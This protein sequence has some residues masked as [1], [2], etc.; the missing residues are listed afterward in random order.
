MSFTALIALVRKDL[1][2]F[3]HDRRSV[4]MSFAAPIVIASFFG[5]LFQGTS[6]QGNQARIPVAVVDQ[7]QTELSEKLIARLRE[8]KQVQVE[9]LPLDQALDQVRRGKTT[10]A[11]RIPAGFSE[12]ATRTFFSG[13]N[14]PELVLD[15]DPSHTMELGLVRGLLTEAAM[16]VVSAEMFTGPAGRKSLDTSLDQLEHSHLAGAERSDLKRLLESA[17]AWNIRQEQQPATERQS[18]LSLP[19]TLKEEG[20]TSRSATPY[21]SYA[22]AFAGMS[23][24]FILFMGI[25]AGI[26]ILVTRRSGLWKRLCAAP[27]SRRLLLGGRAL[28]ATLISLII[29]GVVYLFARLVFNVRIE[30][31]AAGFLGV[32]LAFSL[33]TATFGLLIASLGRTPEATRGLAI[34][35]TLILVMLGGAWVPAFI[36]P[37]WLQKL[38]LFI[39]TRWAVDGLDAMTWR[40]LGFRAALGPI[41][42]LLT[43]ALAFSLI[44]LARFRWD[45]EA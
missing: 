30:G 41:A 12:G 3:F 9:A 6:G 14:K 8:D 39:P 25:E 44:T 21:N 13:E 5:F 34:F 16:S 42:V 36:F 38:S 23:V 40:G 22:H 15:Y 2:L 33:M 17:R 28:S 37:A 35:A 10:M 45:A 7:D 31:S 29:L 11:L 24:Q 43:F 19:Y 18:G 20:L 32:C 26:S 1:K 27:L 4:I